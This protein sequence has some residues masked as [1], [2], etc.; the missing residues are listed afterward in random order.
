MLRLGIG[1]ELLFAV[2]AFGAVEDWSLA[3]LEGGIGALF[4]VWATQ[5]AISGRIEIV[6]SPLYWPATGFVLIVAAQLGLGLTAYRYANLV[7]STKC[8]AYGMLLFLTIQCLTDPRLA[9][10]RF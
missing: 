9:K 1:L 5:G 4:L 3:A 6:P 2:L 8:I 7:A 10:T